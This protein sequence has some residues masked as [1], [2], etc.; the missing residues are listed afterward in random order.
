MKITNKFYAAL[1]AVFFAFAFIACEGPAGEDGIAGADGTDG[2]D[3]KDGEEQCAVCHNSSS[4]LYA[5]QLQYESSM[6]WL[7]TSYG[8]GSSASCAPCHSNEGF[9]QWAELG[10]MDAVEGA[11][12]PTPP[13][14]RTCHNIHET[15]TTDDYGL[16]GTAS[17]NLIGD[18]TDNAAVDFGKGNMCA[19]CHQTRARGYN[20]DPA[21][22]S[23]G[24]VNINSSH[25]GPH[26][27]PQSNVVKANGGY[28]VA[29]QSYGNSSMH[30]NAVDGCVSCHIN[31]NADHTWAANETFCESCHSDGID[32]EAYQDEMRELVQVLEDALVAEGLLAVEH[33]G[34][35]GHPVS[36]EITTNDK[37]GALFNYFMLYEDG[38]WGVHNPK[39]FKAL[40]EKSAAVFN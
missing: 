29:G 2:Q 12:E 33:E 17:F 14:C 18:H 5:K 22:G 37:A 34:E 21:N 27:G 23:G 25:W 4:M 24:E 35:M 13:N 30:A 3:G 10:D 11:A 39:Y 28:E 16:K 40:A 9:N 8:R 19:K 31:E 20:L 26:H 1:I 38:S 6:H 7:G 36:G 32:Y 15:Y